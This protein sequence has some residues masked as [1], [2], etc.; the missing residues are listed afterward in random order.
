MGG[1]PEENKP[2]SARAVAPAIMLWWNYG[3]ARAPRSP[4][5]PM[6]YG[7]QWVQD[8]KFDGYRLQVQRQGGA[9]SLLYLFGPWL[10]A[11]I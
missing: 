7:P 11:L 9:A 8:F 4:S 10:A 1:G 6:V 2:A 3:A 5:T